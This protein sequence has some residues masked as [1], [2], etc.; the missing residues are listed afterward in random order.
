LFGERGLF[1]LQ[2]VGHRSLTPTPNDIQIG[3]YFQE[4]FF[5][6]EN[7]REKEI[8]QKKRKI[9]LSILYQKKG[10]RKKRKKGFDQA[11]NLSI[12]GGLGDMAFDNRMHVRSI[13]LGATIGCGG[14]SGSGGEDG[15]REGRDIER[16]A[17]KGHRRGPTSGNRGDR[18]RERRGSEGSGGGGGEGVWTGG[19]HSG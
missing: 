10:K 18:G 12:P 3:I 5:F 2:W 16:D 19:E 4:I 14:V 11:S 13:G 17:R 9:F 15:R 7:I 6:S 1:D 8:E